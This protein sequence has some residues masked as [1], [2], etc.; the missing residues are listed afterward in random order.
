MHNYIEY[1]KFIEPTS[2]HRYGSWIKE[3]LYLKPNNVFDN[4]Q[5]KLCDDTIITSSNCS[6]SIDEAIKCYKI[7]QDCIEKHNKEGLNLFSFVEQNIRIGS[8]RLMHI[9]YKCK[10]KDNGL[11]QFVTTWLIGIGCHNIWLDDFEDFVHYYH[12]EDKFGIKHNNKNKPI[13]L[14][15]K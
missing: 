11:P 8:Y 12:L 10:Y 5:F 14:K 9:A 1:K 7:L 6:V 3:K 15:M 13:K 2:K 4:I